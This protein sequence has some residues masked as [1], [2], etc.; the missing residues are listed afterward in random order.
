MILDFVLELKDRASREK[1][2]G[3]AIEIAKGN[4]HPPIF[5]DTTKH[6]KE[7]AQFACVVQVPKIRTLYSRPDHL[8]AC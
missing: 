8:W 1:R 4:L 2:I 6:K 5:N 7:A 3:I